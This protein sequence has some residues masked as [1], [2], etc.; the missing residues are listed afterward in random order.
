MH[1]EVKGGVSSYQNKF[2]LRKSIVNA[3]ETV[4][5]NGSMRTHERQT[6]TRRRIPNVKFLLWRKKMIQEGKTEVGD[7]G[8]RQAARLFTTE[9]HG[10]QS[11][12]TLAV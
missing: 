4:V 10:G 3:Q 1:C 7:L 8:L 12:R 9:T 5:V 6:R 11:C 2:R